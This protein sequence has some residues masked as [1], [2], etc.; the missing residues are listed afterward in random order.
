MTLS[1]TS[2]WLISLAFYP[3]YLLLFHLTSR[4]LAPHL[5]THINPSRSV[6]PLYAS[7]SLL[8][9]A[10]F[11]FPSQDHPA[12]STS[13][14]L[15]C[16]V[17]IFLATLV[18]HNRVMLQFCQLHQLPMA[19]LHSCFASDT[20]FPLLCYAPVLPATPVFHCHV[21]F[22]FCQLYEF[23]TAVLR[24]GFASYTSFPLLYYVPDLPALPVSHCC[25]TFCQLHRHLSSA[26]FP[27]C[28]L[29]RL[30][31]RNAT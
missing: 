3:S 25:I 31:S 15:L 9:C 8:R 4:K 12:C 11:H 17:P 2:P 18:F 1:L 20:S 5:L 13:F 6:S 23:P 7:S 27:S 14:P 29:F 19:M 24:S 21:T 22:L 10:T 30:H 26:I 16:Y 28:L